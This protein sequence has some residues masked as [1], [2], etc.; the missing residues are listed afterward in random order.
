MEFDAAPGEMTF[1]RMGLWDEKPFMYIVKG[2]SVELPADQRKE[3]NAQTDP[4]WPHVHARL[5]CDFKEFLTLFPANHAHG[6]VGDRVRALKY[7]CE[8]TGITPIIGG[9]EAN[10]YPAPIWERVK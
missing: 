4:T 7:L 1:A 8:I 9:P 6:M 2:E 3:L 5:R 10:D